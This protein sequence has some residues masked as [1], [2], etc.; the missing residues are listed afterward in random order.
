MTPSSLTWTRILTGARYWTLRIQW[1]FVIPEKSNVSTNYIARWFV[2]CQVPKTLHFSERKNQSYCALKVRRGVWANAATFCRT[3]KRQLCVF[4]VRAQPSTPRH[5]FTF[6]TDKAYPGSHSK[7][8]LSPKSYSL[9]W[10]V[11]FRCSVK[12]G[13]GQ[14][15]PEKKIDRL[16]YS[17]CFNP[18]DLASRCREP[19]FAVRSSYVCT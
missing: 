4:I 19:R 16:S 7:K 15:M 18:A 8:M 13:S 6:L 10:L 12:A 9:R 17:S 3:L 14:V 11:T 2:C 1:D 5:T